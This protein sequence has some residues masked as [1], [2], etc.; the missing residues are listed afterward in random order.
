MI[1]YLMLKWDAFKKF[2]WKNINIKNYYDRS[3]V[4]VEYFSIYIFNLYMTGGSFFADSCYPPS[5]CG[6]VAC[7]HLCLA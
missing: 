7:V 1:G 6:D 5:S 3:Y 4:L 2:D